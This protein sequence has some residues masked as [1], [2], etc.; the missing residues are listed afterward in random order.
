MQVKREHGREGKSHS[1]S[2]SFTLHTAKSLGRNAGS[3]LLM[4]SGSSLASRAILLGPGGGHTKGGSL[5][6]TSGSSSTN[7]GSGS[8]R[9]ITGRGETYSGSLNIR[10]GSSDDVSG[11]IKIMSGNNLLSPAHGIYVGSSFSHMSSPGV[12]IQATDSAGNN[13]GAIGLKLSLIHI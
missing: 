13:G 3:I 4:S 2:G 8:I 7:H 12:M 6:L 9:G 1:A 10:T 11:S 5:S